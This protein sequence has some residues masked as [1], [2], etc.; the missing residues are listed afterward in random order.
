MGLWFRM[1]RWCCCLALRLS[2]TSSTQVLIAVWV[3]VSVIFVSTFQSNL[4]ASLTLPKYPSCPET[5][6]QL[7]N[8]V[9]GCIR[10]NL[11]K[12]VKKN[13]T[14]WCFV[15]AWYQLYGIDLKTF[16]NRS[17]NCSRASSPILIWYP[18]WRWDNNRNLNISNYQYW[19]QILM[20]F[21]ESL[22]IYVL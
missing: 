16:W 5:L 11:V 9:K 22:F 6:P 14:L 21:L 4:T 10:W 2:G 7:V 1:W 13:H 8:T 12:F 17:C 3:V 18:V 19:L 15:F 20:P